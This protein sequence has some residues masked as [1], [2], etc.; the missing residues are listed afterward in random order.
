MITVATFATA[1]AGTAVCL[2][3]LVYCSKPVDC[4]VNTPGAADAGRRQVL[5]MDSTIMVRGLLF[6]ALYGR[7][8]HWRLT[9][10][11][12]LGGSPPRCVREPLEVRDRDGIRPRGPRGSALLLCVLCRGSPMLGDLPGVSRSVERYF[13]YFLS[14]LSY[15][16]FFVSVSCAV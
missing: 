13:L 3:D 15:T 4:F 10:D 11:E 14:V 8:D 12:R 9:A 6:T 2:L 1:T 7:S 5:L 16:M